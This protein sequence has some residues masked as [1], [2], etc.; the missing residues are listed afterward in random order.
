[1]ILKTILDP[2]DY[3]YSIDTKGIIEKHK[4]NN[5]RILSTKCITYMD[6]N[7]FIICTENDLQNNHLVNNKIF[8]YQES[9]AKKYS[10]DII[11]K[12]TYNNDF[13]TFIKNLNNNDF[14]E[15]YE[16]ATKYNDFKC[17][18]TNDDISNISLT[19][20]NKYHLLNFKLDWSK[21]YIKILREYIDRI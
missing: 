6:N 1:M 17:L 4:I 16:L 21:I 12:L 11:D 19:L 10:K 13:N 18:K 20:N 9:F 3:I 14:Y 5:I 15:L 8:T 7:D 2:G